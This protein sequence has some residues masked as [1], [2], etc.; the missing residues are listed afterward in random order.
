M[1]LR[2]LYCF[3][4][5][6]TII[7]KQLSNIRNKFTLTAYQIV[8][9]CQTSHV[10]H[11]Y[12]PNNKDALQI[13]VKIIE[14]D[15][16]DTVNSIIKATNRQTEVKDEQL[17]ALNE[18]HR[19]LEAF[20]NTY[21]GNQRLYYERR[22]KQ[23]NS[24]SEIEK[25][26]IVT[27]STQI[28]AA[29]SMFFDCPHLASRYY[30]RLLKTVNGLFLPDHKELPYYTCAYLLY[31]LEYLFR[32]KLLPTQFRKYRYHILMLFKYDFA[33]E[34]IPMLNA[35]KITGLCDKIL[36]CIN[37]NKNFMLELKKLM[38]I[39]NKHVNDLNDQELTKSALL[40]DI[41]KQDFKRK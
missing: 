31:K 17:M 9:G 19:K 2:N 40:I 28:K 37:D 4:N 15:D 5:G 3:N 27:I 11:F 34:K 13:P 36:T 39:I 18:F 10:L 23:Y 30:G 6:V 35:N 33:Q 8:N 26:R 16:E 25:V 24:V 14:T 7:C 21:S 22:S 29:A 32:N 20:Y 12:M 41:L 38:E 1:I